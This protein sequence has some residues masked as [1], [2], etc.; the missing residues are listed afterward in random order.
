MLVL[1]NFLGELA[2]PVLG[3]FGLAINDDWLTII[4]FKNILCAGFLAADLEK[5][6]GKLTSAKACAPGF[7]V[8]VSSNMGK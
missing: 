5:C 2:D 4:A 1:C 7:H 8:K 3:L 6:E